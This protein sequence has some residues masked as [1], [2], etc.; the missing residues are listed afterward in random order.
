ML[1]PVFRSRQPLAHDNC[2]IVISHQIKYF[3]NHTNLRHIFF[4]FFIFQQ[5]KESKKTV[6]NHGHLL[7]YDFTFC[8][9]KIQCYPIV[10]FLI[11]ILN[12]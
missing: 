9:L 8:D 7:L 2:Q 1:V 11:Q 5:K 3:Y 12:L 10:L 6:D 4:H